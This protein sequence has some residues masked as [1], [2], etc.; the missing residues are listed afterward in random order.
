MLFKFKKRAVAPASQ[1]SFWG[2]GKWAAIILSVCAGLAVYWA[3]M[4]VYQ[5]VNVVVATKQIDVL[6]KIGPA[7][8]TIAKVAG[9]DRHPEAFTDPS[10]VVGSY[11]AVPLTKG[12]QVL[13]TKVTRDL[14][15]M[16]A[17]ANMKANETFITL[18]QNEAVWPGFLKDGDLVTVTACYP[19]TGQVIDEA[20]ARVVSF[21]GPIPLV[22]D[23]KNLREAQS[24]GNEKEI[25]LAMSVDEAHRV[26]KAIATAKSVR[27]LPRHPGLEG[28]TLGNQ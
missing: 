12:E 13:A 15:K 18:R 11:A 24:G 22:S 9:R 25:T 14:G 20:V 21:S 19:D 16:T 23:F 5:P 1:K 6:K 4:Q 2:A 17:I 8:V 26:M 27:L 7:D 28:I 3:L 10:Q